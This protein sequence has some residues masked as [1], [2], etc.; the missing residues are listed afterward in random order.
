[1]NHTETPLMPDSV[2][3]IATELIQVEEAFNLAMTSNDISQIGACITDDWVLV[4]PEVGVVS[5]ARSTSPVDTSEHMLCPWRIASRG[6][7][8]IQRHS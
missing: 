1:M 4:T 8:R 2:P 3:A 7:R 6:S 5:R